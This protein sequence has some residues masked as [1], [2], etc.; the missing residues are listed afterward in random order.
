MLDEVLA[1]AD[2]VLI[3]SVNPGFGGQRLI[4][5][6]LDKVRR[7]K[8]RR[9]ELGLKFAIEI[10]GG[11]TVENLPEVVEAGCDWIVAGATIFESS[12]PAATVAEMRR[13]AESA[14]C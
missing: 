1:L 14:R 4:P 2:F 5:Y 6:T 7:L 10:D 12:H 8:Q 13:I 11:V 3:M 9:A